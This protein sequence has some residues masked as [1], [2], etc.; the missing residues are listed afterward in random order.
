LRRELIALLRRAVPFDSWC[1]AF[2]DPDSQLASS[3]TGVSPAATDIGR[4]LALEY[5]GDDL[6]RLLILADGD[7]PAVAVLSHNT[8]SATSCG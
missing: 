2:A 1:W 4:F 6:D 5:G 7:G 8:A 3:G